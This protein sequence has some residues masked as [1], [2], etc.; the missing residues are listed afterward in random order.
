MDA[1]HPAERHHQTQ[2]DIT[3]T[4]RRWRAA[5]LLAPAA[6]TMAALVTPALVT[7]AQAS[8]SWQLT[9]QYTSSPVC[10]LT[11][12]GTEYLEMNLNGS[13]STSLTF[14]ASGLPAG[15][16]YND[17][18]YY[19]ASSLSAFIDSGPGPMPPGSSN[20]TGPFT[21]TASPQDFGEAYL[22]TVIPAGLA[23]GSSFT[24]TFWASDG[25]TRQTESV[26]V[27][28]KASCARRY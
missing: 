7:P 28:I 9:D 12:G 15:A 13:W 6:I 21:I 26:P 3:L 11:S 8:P 16:S 18:I 2:G 23:A 14:G 5:A 27:V 25:T 20:G 4:F 1:R 19:F 17:T 24:A 22:V 10:F